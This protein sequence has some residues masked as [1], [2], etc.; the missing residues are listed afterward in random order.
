MKLFKY[1]EEHAVG[2][3]IVMTVIAVLA[4]LY[5]GLVH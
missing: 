5:F 2:F 1:L 3:T 4:G